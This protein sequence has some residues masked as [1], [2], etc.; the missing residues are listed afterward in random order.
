[1]NFSKP[2]TE[3]IQER[4]SHR[5]YTGHAL[6]KNL[7]EKIVDLLENHDL[8]SPF[9]DYAGKARFKL[10]SIPEFD[11]KEKKKLGTYSFIKGAQDFIV[12]AVEKS[13][14]DLEHYG[15]LLET[16]ILSATD[17]GLGT[18]W[19]GGYFNRS[20]F[21]RKISCTPNEILPAITPIGYTAQ[22]RVREKIIR[23]VAKADKRLPWDK[24][25]FEGNPSILL[26]K[27]KTEEYSKL[28]EMIR[29]GP[30]AGNKQPWRIIKIPDK[31]VFHFYTINPKDGRFLKYSK[32]RP[33]DIGIAVCHF[34]L[35]AKELDVKGN[36][37]F[38]KPQI[39][40]VDDLLY[41]I[42]WK[43]EK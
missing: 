31:K 36:W 18:C 24:L 12:G 28:L 38:E 22:K 11:P 8:K 35:T 23:S 26:T 13:Q 25:F 32:F 20:L 4:I 10:L 1:M 6:G 14:Y 43:G 40:G 21:S 42:S 15:Y 3:I 33:L 34:D 39:S 27:N 30:S 5:T 41:K 19:I 9:S 29:I 7:R 16:I 2:V 37:I 17:L